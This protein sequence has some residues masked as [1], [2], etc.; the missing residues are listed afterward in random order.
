MGYGPNGTLR[1]ADR[2]RALRRNVDKVEHAVSGK[3]DES[4]RKHQ[5]AE[6]RKAEARD[7]TDP[8]EIGRLEEQ[9]ERARRVEQAVRNEAERIRRDE[10]EPAK[11]AL[12]EAERNVADDVVAESSRD[13][14]DEKARYDQQAS[15]AGL[16]KLRRKQ[17]KRDVALE[18]SR[19]VRG[20]PDWLPPGWVDEPD[21]PADAGERAE[22][23]TTSY[24]PARVA[25]EKA[26]AAERRR[27]Q[28]RV[29]RRAY[30]KRQG[31]AF[32]RDQANVAG[33]EPEVVAEV[34]AELEEER[35]ALVAR[36]KAAGAPLTGV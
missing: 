4:E 24:Q 18:H 13:A 21:P 2:L 33:E 1:G 34:I 25:A 3:L 36:R 12:E 16:E 6:R 15:P 5:L 10:L 14:A 19:Q 8:N 11:A 32:L 31:S 17:A 29:D 7:A 22:A 30:L 20:D 35:E 23:L 9:A 28:A 26:E 27:K